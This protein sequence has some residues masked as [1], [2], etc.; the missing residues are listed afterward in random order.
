M[1]YYITCVEYQLPRIKH[2]SPRIHSFHTS[3]GGGGGATVESRED[4]E[5]GGGGEWWFS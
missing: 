5:G 2:A 3:L 4:G 1:W